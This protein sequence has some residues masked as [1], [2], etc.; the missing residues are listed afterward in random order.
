MHTFEKLSRE[1]VSGFLRAKGREVVNGRGEPI[2]LSGWGLGNWL[3]C[4]GYMWKAGERG[5]RPRRL[6]QVV[7]ELAGS[8]YAEGFWRQFRK[9]YICREN[10]LRMAQLGYNSVRLPIGWRV[11]MEEEPGIRWR[12]EGFQLIDQLLS[13]C[14]E[15]GLYVFLDLHGAPGGQTGANIDDCIDDFP[16]LFT[17]RDSWD[18]AIALWGELARRYRDRWIV[19][20]YDLLN[21]PLRPDDG[22]RPCQY[23][24]PRLRD[25]YVEA[26]AEIRKYD[27][28]HLLSLE[29]S[30]WATDP[31]VFCQDYDDNMLIHFHRY[32][33]LP[34]MRAY[35]EFLELSERWQKPL[36]LCESGEN[37][38]EW[39]EALYPLGARL[40]IGY[41]I[42]PWK[43]MA[44][45]NS[46]Y[47]VRMPKNWEKFTAY[48]GGG[49]RPS[50]EEA[51]AMLD[52]YLHNMLLQNCE[53]N[54]AV[55]ASVR[56]EPGCSVRATDFDEGGCRGLCKAQALSGYRNGTGMRII[57]PEVMPEK[58]FG[59]DCN[60]DAFKLALLPG[61]YAE[62]TFFAAKTGSAVRIEFKEG[63]AGAVEVFQD[64]RSLGI[65]SM[66]SGPLPLAPADETV[67][68]LEGKAGEAVLERIV[69][70][71]PCKTV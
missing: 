69:Y 56:R 42:W 48:T 17:D 58:R 27:T 64:G 13:W 65:V 55:S 1:R 70:C 60:W 35:R 38:P 25:F 66:G 22:R 39:F 28:A 59:F 43:K 18:K 11:L 23:L 34:D 7:R 16:R 46:P 49:P 20:G 9:N 31:A 19:G 50:Y 36:W 2:L 14:E 32:A 4:E 47:S 67:I 63:S 15:A 44:C 40:G 45:K 12:E 62:Y 61:E 37:L 21:E 51:Q 30:S 54:P 6:E 8:E 71:G 29:G 5:D 24:L 53:E 26:I 57:E 3:L 41:N 52:A 33:V 68:R 10:I